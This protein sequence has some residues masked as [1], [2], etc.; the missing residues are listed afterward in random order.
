MMEEKQINAMSF[1]E[2]VKVCGGTRRDE[3][4][5]YLVK[6]VMQMMIEYFG[7]DTRLP[8]A[9]V[10]H[11][12]IQKGVVNEICEKDV[13]TAMKVLDRFYEMI[14][15]ALI[16]DPNFDPSNVRSKVMELMRK[17]MYDRITIQQEASI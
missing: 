9:N 1:H 14:A 4:I 17:K 7:R 16:D 13:V 8:D 6:I 3:Q 10:L 5:D 15:S 2:L 11:A 12:L